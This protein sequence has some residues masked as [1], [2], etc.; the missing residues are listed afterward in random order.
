MRTEILFN[1][2]KPLISAPD[3]RYAFLKTDWDEFNQAVDAA[4]TEKRFVF[5]N[6]NIEFID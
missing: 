3:K 2:P 5:K 1:C 6:S 4:D